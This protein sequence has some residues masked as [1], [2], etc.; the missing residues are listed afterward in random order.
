MRHLTFPPFSQQAADA[1][2]QRLDSL[3]KVP[4]SL[5]EL[6][7][8]AIRLGGITDDARPSFARK[9]V[10]LFAGDHG[11]TA[12]GVS[13]TG[14]EVTAIQV[15]NFLAGGGTINAFCRNAGARLVVVDVG[16]ADALEGAEGLVRRKVMPGCRDFSEGPAMTREEAL[17]CL[18]VGI[19]MAREEAARGTQLLVAGEMG[20]GNTSPSSAIASV[21][22]GAPVE[23]VTGLGSGIS[24]ES[25]R[26]KTELIRQGIARNQPDPSDP[27]DVLAKV[28][29]TE[30]AAMAGLMLGGASLRIPV[31]VDG[32][33]AGAAAAI[34]VGLHPEARA[35]LVGSHASV[36]PGHRLL[37][38]HLGIP[39]YTNFGLRLGEGTGA[40]LL[41]PII[42]A[43]VRI[44]TEMRTLAELDIQR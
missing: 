30:L 12:K 22:T 29:G 38:R 1:V 27:L 11:I 35:L 23:E 2:R 37:M 7:E 24:S 42:D 31:V 25:L 16:V 33:I 20:I 10:V 5:G 4:G 34:A 21:L 19:D 15:R 8:L 36:E 14:P 40:A 26:R 9:A 13:A 17:A 28:G 39:T 44:L 3:A 18:Q 6:E 43:S 32:F 41:F